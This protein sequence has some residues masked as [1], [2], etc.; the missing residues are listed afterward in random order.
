MPQRLK[1]PALA[2]GE[3]EIGPQRRDKKIAEPAIR[4]AR[5]TPPSH[6]PT[7]RL[8]DTQ[9]VLD[10]IAA[11]VSATRPTLQSEAAFELEVALDGAHGHLVGSRIEDLRTEAA[12]LL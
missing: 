7:P 1:F 2:K 12:Q 9:A 3:E 11:R 6:R 8:V 10:T 5:S 4:L